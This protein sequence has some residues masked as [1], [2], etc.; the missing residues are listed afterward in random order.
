MIESADIAVTTIH[1]AVAL[2]GLEPGR[3]T[4]SAT[5]V[6]S[7]FGDETS[8]DV[9]LLVTSIL[10]WLGYLSLR[11]SGRLRI[12]LVTSFLLLGVAIGPSGA[13]LIAGP[14]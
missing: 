11:I 12:P 13:G 5:I 8:S 9:L 4:V 1:T 10:L 3:L 6:E 2:I 14:T 7:L